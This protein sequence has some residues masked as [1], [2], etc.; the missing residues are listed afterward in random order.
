MKIPLDMIGT[1]VGFF[2]K[3][4]EILKNGNIKTVNLPF[5]PRSICVLPNDTLICCDYTPN[6]RQYDKDLNLIN[7]IT[8][9]ANQVSYATSNNKDRIYMSDTNNHQIVMTD[10]NFNKLG[11]VGTEGD[12]INQL[13]YPWGLSFSNDYLYVCDCNN[14]KI[15]KL[16]DQLQFVQA[17]K[18]DYEP[19][20]IKVNKNVACVTPYKQS[21]TYFHEI[22]NFTLLHKYNHCGVIGNI[23]GV[24]YQ[25][26]LKN[27]KLY[28]Y[29][30]NGKIIDETEIDKFNNLIN[31][32]FD[33]CLEVFNNK[34]VCAAFKSKKLILVG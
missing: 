7:T 32:Y 9:V 31:H 6:I 24:F 15:Q 16:T 14:R 12:G 27:K 8:T 1:L 11:V 26:F 33:S 25:Y 34:I 19:W 28:C 20:H 23:G 17:Y 29:D 5:R 21:F 22:N 30:D 10:L 18:L 3:P 4:K 13:N 2:V